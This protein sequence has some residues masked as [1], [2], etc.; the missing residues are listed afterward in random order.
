MADFN[1]LPDEIVEHVLN[2]LFFSRMTIGKR[3]RWFNSTMA[4]R[5]RDEVRTFASACCVNT[6]LKR[7]CSLRAYVYN[8]YRYYK[9]VVGLTYR[10]SQHN[11]PV[12]VFAHLRSSKCPWLRL[13]GCVR[14]MVP[15]ERRTVPF[16]HNT[17][18]VEYRGRDVVCYLTIL[19]TSTPVDGPR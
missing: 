15:C 18:I 11:V 9:H 14:D 1:L 8:T 4:T 6:T 16:Y 3:G 12:D 5:L 19:S 13:S 17:P 2:F 7:T 10:T